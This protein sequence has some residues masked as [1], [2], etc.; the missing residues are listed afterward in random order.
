MKK[1]FLLCLSTVLI[2]SLTACGGQGGGDASKAALWHEGVPDNILA[3]GA[4]SEDL[5]DLDLDTAFMLYR[6]EDWGLTRD[7]LTGGA[8][9]RSA[10]ATC[11]EVAVL[12]F[13]SADAAKT[14]LEAMKAYVQGQIDSNVDY[15]PAEIPKLEN[16]WLEQREGTLL[17]AVVNDMEIAKQVEF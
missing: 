12:I 4:C 9:R 1:L 3:D 8:V 13:D 11:E 6:L 14:G 10:G 17:L 2:L 7:N 15:R 5:E 16:A